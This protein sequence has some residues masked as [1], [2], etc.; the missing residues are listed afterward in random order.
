MKIMSEMKDRSTRDCQCSKM[1]PKSL[2]LDGVGE[3]V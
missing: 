3:S 2:N 1:P